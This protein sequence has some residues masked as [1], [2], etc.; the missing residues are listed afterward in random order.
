[1][2]GGP[3]NHLISKLGSQG[4]LS[5]FELISLIDSLDESVH[6]HLR[7]TAHRVRVSMYGNSVYV[8]GLIEFSNICKQ[9][10]LYCG[11]RSGNKQLSRYRLS[12]QEI[13]KCCDEGYELGYRT[14]VLQSGEDAWYTTDRLAELI[15]SIKQSYPDTAVTLS[16]GERSNECYT[17]LYEAGADRFLLRHETASRALYDA[18]HPTMQFE[19]RR[20]R[21]HALQ[22]IGYQ[23]GA[24]FMV[25]L[26][27]QTSA[28]LAEDLLYVQELQ[29]DMIGI[30]PFLPHKATPLRD[31]PPGTIERTLDMI[32]LARLLVPQALIPATTAMGTAHPQ[33]RELALL[34]GANVVM[35]NL[36][37]MSVRDKYMLYNNKICTGDESAQCRFCLERRIEAVG[38][39]MDMGR[40]D[41]LKYLDRSGQPIAPF[42]S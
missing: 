35:P 39:Y 25:G 29:P 34:A 41:S 42:L 7:R 2:E 14:F 31:Q 38:L 17:R 24:G 32:A 4:T 11:L 27:G 30:G 13:I 28:D 21:L 23:I 18:L 3:T 12:L 37:P 6:Q 10:C 22:S 40:G 15:H 8:R 20:E 1:M 5:R 16:I 33:G 36:S 9:N 19:Q 26:P